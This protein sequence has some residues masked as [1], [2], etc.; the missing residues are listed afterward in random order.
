MKRTRR[1]VAQDLLVLEA[2]A[3]SVEAFERLVES[4][5]RPLWLTAR[6]VTGRE[7]L[8]WDALQEGWMAIVRGLRRLSDPA[9]FGAWAHG[10]VRRKGVDFV[11]RDERRRRVLDAAPPRP[12]K[13]TEPSELAES[14]ALAMRHLAAPHREV[15]AL[16]YRDGFDIAHIALLLEIPPGTVKS[17]LHS[18]R[19][20]P[21]ERLV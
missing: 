12:A 7:D 3:G 20:K 10:I 4:W 9:R 21:K 8:A 16:H 13:Q 2:Q 19:Q 17:R 11:R 1:Q 6:R 15:L 18:A 5:Q 14:L